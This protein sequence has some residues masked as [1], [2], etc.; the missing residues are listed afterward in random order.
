MIQYPLKSLSDKLTDLIV[1]IRWNQS[2]GRP[3]TFQ[4]AQNI[5]FKDVL[6]FYSDRCQPEFPLAAQCY[7][8]PFVSFPYVFSQ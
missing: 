1:S 3:S 2:N 6:K 8:R 7:T 5:F 4:A